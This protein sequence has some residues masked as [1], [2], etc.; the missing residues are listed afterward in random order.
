MTEPLSFSSEYTSANYRY[1]EGGN[2]F[3]VEDGKKII[4]CSHMVNLLL[5]RAGYEVPYQNTVALNGDEALQYYDVISPANVKRGDIVLWFNKVSND[6]SR[7]LKHTGIVESYDSTLE[8]EIGSFFGAQSSGP[9]TA[10]FGAVGKAYFWPVPT[11]FLRVKESTRSG[12]TSPAP[13]S[14]PVQA[15]A[16]PLMNFQFP[17]RKPDG[18]QFAGA[19]EVYKVLEKEASGHYLLGSNKFWHGGVHISNASASQC[20]LDEPIRCMADGEVVAYRLNKDYLE[21]PF[22]VNGETKRLKYSSSFC[23]VRHEYK[24]APNPE[25]G[26]NKGKQNKLTFYSLYMH[27]LPFNKYPLSP[28][29]TPKPKVTMQVNDFKAYD[30]LPVSSSVISAGKLTKGSRLEILDQGPVPNTDRIYAK[31]KIITG[32]VKSG[33]QVKREAGSE[34]WFAYLKNGQP[35]ENNAG[36]RVWIEDRIP[37]RERPNYWQ[38]KVNGTVVN[39][40]PLFGAPSD[41]SNGKAAGAP[42]GA[43]QLVMNSVVAFDSQKV[44]SLVSG[45]SLQRMAE[46]TLVSGGPTGAGNVPPTFWACVENTPEN[47]VVKWS[48]TEP[49]SADI[50]INVGVGIKAGDPIGYLGQMENINELEE[51]SSKFQVHVEIFT[52]D[53]GIEGFLNNT[54]GLKIGKQYLSLAKDSLLKFKAPGVG[55]V[56][57]KESHAVDLSKAPIF[58]DSEEWYEVHVEDDGQALV[59]LARKA[60]SN[61]ITQHDW[62][63]LGFQVV[64][65]S[66][67]S[68]DGF[69]DPNDLPP[70]FKKLFEKIDKNN[71]HEIEAEE[72]AEALKNLE[73]RSQWSKLIARHPTEWNDKADQPKW[74]RLSDILKH[75]PKLLEHEKERINNLIFWDKLSGE[76]SP[77]T[78]MV[79]HFHPIEFVGGFTSAVAEL[80]SYDQM[81]R[82]FPASS[83][84]KREEVRGLF[85]KYADRF[86][87]NTAPR[88]AQFFAQV[89]AEVG[90]ALV[91]KVE[92][93]WYRTD[94]LREKFGRYFD[95][96]PAEADQIGYKRIELSQYNS[97]SPAAKSAYTIH[98]EKAYSQFPNEDE[99][100]K[101]IYCCCSANGG[102]VLIQGG[103]VEGIKYKGK[104]FIQLTWKANYQAVED[105]LKVK[106]PEETFQMVSNPDQL[107]E[108]KFGLLS[109]M[110]FW[111]WKKLND[112]V[113]PTTD[114]TTEITKIVNLHTPEA[115]YIKRRNNFTFI[116]QEIGQ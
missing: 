42:L 113:F 3:D 116:Y 70:F 93:L 61:L 12:A 107:L 25:E 28:A 89:K 66:N 44:V 52:A 30:E 96:Y 22:D 37:A 32:S 88:I 69:L 19:D 71:N 41:P 56:D 20:I 1:K 53:A 110:G 98:N 36:D 34:I 101:R 91:G 95:T 26:V 10:P 86:E 65:E 43:V 16:V 9:A 72:L 112:L 13:A 4:D 64:E 49:A 46:C 39:K 105:L 67:S 11:K 84:E 92:D 115:S 81:K 104:G 75:S 108:T 24:S 23:L 94:I 21:S 82:M 83:E 60:G 77:G 73:T 38:G 47:N 103:C 54:A 31:G 8:S 80:V 85:N 2:G 109:A 99:I 68:A 27:L 17:F 50:V 14:A 51:V 100:A 29:E 111:D 57:L 5:T 15:G 102:F 90:D 74:A 76:A 63:D 59:G 79:W 97:L 78:S 114:S 35:Y 62:A 58:K 48:V 7:T 87:I 55:E 33:S 6:Q 45:A 106:I 18:K 40:L